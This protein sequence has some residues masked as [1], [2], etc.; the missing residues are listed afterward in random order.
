MTYGSYFVHMIFDIYK[1]DIDRR[2]YFLQE[3]Q[4]YAINHSF[5]GRALEEGE[6]DENEGNE[7]RTRAHSMVFRYIDLIGPPLN[8]P[9]FSLILETKSL[10][11]KEVHIGPTILSRT[12]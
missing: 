4:S 5:L 1:L 3:E 8:F 10:K 9:F 12:Q 11:M 2:R 7:E 6:S